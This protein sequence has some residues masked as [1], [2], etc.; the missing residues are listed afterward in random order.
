MRDAVVAECG[1]VVGFVVVA[2]ERGAE[3]AAEEFEDAEG[4]CHFGLDCGSLLG[5]GL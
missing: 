3:E 2:G 1:L 5:L 4:I